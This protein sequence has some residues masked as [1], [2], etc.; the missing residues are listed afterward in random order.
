EIEIYV[1]DYP[2]ERLIAWLESIVGPL[3]PVKPA[4]TAMVYPSSIGPVVV[5]PQIEGGAFVGVWFNSPNSP[6]AT[7]AD[8]ARQAA[9]ELVASCGAAQASTSQKYLGGRRTSSWR[10]Q[11]VWSRL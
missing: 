10:S 9:K 4:G 5:R 8:C 3:A 1:C 6:W 7:D 2:A 11:A